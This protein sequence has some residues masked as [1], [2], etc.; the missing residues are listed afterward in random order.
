MAFFYLNKEPVNPS[1]NRRRATKREFK[2]FCRLNQSN[3]E[4][5]FELHCFAL[6]FLYML[7]CRESSKDTVKDDKTPAFQLIMDET[8]MF[9]CKL[10]QTDKVKDLVEL[11]LQAYNLIEEYIQN[12]GFGNPF[13]KF[14][15]K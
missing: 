4:T 15:R 11:R 7:W 2:N 9:L 12:N 5:F 10:M 14:T 6:R 13:K 1:L 3:K 8:R